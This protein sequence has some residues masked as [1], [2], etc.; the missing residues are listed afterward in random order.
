MAGR[1]KMKMKLK[2]SVALILAAA[3]LLVGCSG[4]ELSENQ[5][6]AVDTE[7][8]EMA[9]SP[10]PQWTEEELK[11]VFLRENQAEEVIA[12]VPAP[13]GAYELAGVVMF[14]DKE[15]ENLK[16]AFMDKNGHCQFCGLEA[17]PYSPPELQYLGD[18]EV[19][20]SFSDESGEPQDCVVSF[21]RN[22][23]HVYFKSETPIQESGE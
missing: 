22:G 3:L 11:A 6:T 10:Q 21:S 19:S 2:K 15:S 14:T 12:S 13:D 17:Q 9:A 7:S 20:F 16:L 1:E 23:S 5:K 4:A 18:G 8:S